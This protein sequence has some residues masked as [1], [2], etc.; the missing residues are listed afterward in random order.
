MWHQVYSY[1]L[2]ARG[3]Q[4]LLKLEIR[5]KIVMVEVAEQGVQSR[6][7]KSLVRVWK[8]GLLDL[9]KTLF[10]DA[11]F[12]CNWLDQAAQK[13][14]STAGT[15]C[16]FRVNRRREQCNSVGTN[17]F[18]HMKSL[19]HQYGSLL[20]SQNPTNHHLT[21]Y[22]SLVQRM[23]NCQSVWTRGRQ[24]V[25]CPSYLNW[26]TL[27]MWVLVSLRV[28]HFNSLTIVRDPLLVQ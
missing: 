6:T 22:T 8:W 20:M 1:E 10:A 27:F 4:V 2:L 5:K 7:R 13:H 28:S 19:H 24:I 11:F 18:S 21:S 3:Q 12:F 17:H 9:K 15:R 26:S 25:T 23:S 14:M 16:T